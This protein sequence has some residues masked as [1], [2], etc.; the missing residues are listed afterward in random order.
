M[1]CLKQILKYLEW[2]L[3]FNLVMRAESCSPEQIERP[4]FWPPYWRLGCKA[5]R[6]CAQAFCRGQNCS[7]SSSDAL[8]MPPDILKCVE[9]FI[10]CPWK[11]EPLSRNSWLKLILRICHNYV[12]DL[13]Q[14]ILKRSA[15]NGTRPT[16]AS[17][18]YPVKCI[19]K[20]WRKILQRP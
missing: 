1:M 15:S 4:P 2:Y 3:R 9:A 7:R 16:I 5:W 12:V 10:V 18:L 11:M 17:N 14:I 8:K 19:N 13:R 6:R 20:S